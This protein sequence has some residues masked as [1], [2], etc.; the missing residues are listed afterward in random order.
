MLCIKLWLSYSV[1][2]NNALWIYH[3]GVHLALMCI[4]DIEFPT[5]SIS[6]LQRRCCCSSSTTIPPP[7]PYPTWDTLWKTSR[8]SSVSTRIL[9]S[10]MSYVWQFGRQCR[11]SYVGAQ[12]NNKKFLQDEKLAKFNWPNVSDV[13]LVCAEKV[14]KFV[15]LTGDCIYSVQEISFLVWVKLPACI[16]MYHCWY[17]RWG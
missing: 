1:D 3:C 7:D 6:I 14:M 10:L 17:L 8:Q 4:C 5:K 13:R 15:K 2:A 16:L 9:C 11:C 12:S